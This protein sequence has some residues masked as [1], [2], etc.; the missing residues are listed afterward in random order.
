MAD[1]A[2]SA[3]GEVTEPGTH[4]EREILRR[5]ATVLAGDVGVEIL[6]DPLDAAVVGAVG[7]EETQGEATPERGRVPRCRRF[8]RDPRI[9]GPRVPFSRGIWSQVLP[10]ASTARGEEL[11]PFRVPLCGKDRPGSDPIPRRDRPPG[12]PPASEPRGGLPQTGD[13]PSGGRAR[14]PVVEAMCEGFEAR[15][16]RGRSVPRRGFP[17]GWEPVG[18]RA[19][20][21]RD[22]SGR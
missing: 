19:S 22:E 17:P 1:R 3:A 8:P 9:W 16:E 20:L 10:I 15:E 11:L 7:R 5:S 6:P 4:G 21:L 14:S 18:I 13:A 12:K 2:R